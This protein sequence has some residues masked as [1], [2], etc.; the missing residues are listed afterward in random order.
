VNNVTRHACP[1][2]PA[3]RRQAGNANR[4]KR[5]SNQLL[6][7]TRN[8]LLYSLLAFLFLGFNPVLAADKFSF[9]VFGDNQDGDKVFID[10]I[11]RLNKDAS[12]AFAVNNGDL[13]PYG[14]EAEYKK[15]LKM[16]KKLNIKLYNVPGNHDLVAGGGKYY[17]KYIGPYYHSMDYANSHFIFLNNAFKDSFDKVQFNWLREDLENN[18]KEHV[19]VFMHRPTFDPNELYNGYVMSGRQVVEELMRL[20][21][22]YNVNYVFAGHI[23]GYAKAKR[24]SITYIVTAGAGASL[25]LPREIGGIF[26]YIKITVDGD[27]ILDEVKMIYGE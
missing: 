17:L 14:K 20:F 12:L 27:K 18:K 8:A 1:C 16:T 24:G 13:T 10:L 22:R 11:D 26:H 6:R 19:F 2:L 9:A 7:I 4:V 5:N 3:G 25:Y 15:Y 23:H 21:E